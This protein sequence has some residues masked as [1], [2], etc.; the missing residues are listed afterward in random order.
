MG[1]EGKINAKTRDGLIPL[2]CAARSGHLGVVEILIGKGDNAIQATTKNGLTPLHMAAQGNHA[3]CIELLL[4]KGAKVG[5]GETKFLIL[6]FG[7][8]NY[9]F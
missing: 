7:C 4:A 8:Q 5:F 1:R 2:H 9:S 6:T 3:K